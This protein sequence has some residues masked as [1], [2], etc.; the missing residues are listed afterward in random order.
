MQKSRMRLVQLLRKLSIL[1]AAVSAQPGH[2]HA[3]N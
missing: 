1:F 2:I 3:I